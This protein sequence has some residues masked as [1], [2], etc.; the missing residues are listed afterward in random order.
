MS[1]GGKKLRYCIRANC[2]KPVKSPFKYC[3]ACREEIKGCLRAGLTGGEISRRLEIKLSTVDFY[4]LKLRHE[5][6]HTRLLEGHKY[7]DYKGK[8]EAMLAELT[9]K[10]GIKNWKGKKGQAVLAWINLQN[11]AEI[12]N[13]KPDH[14]EIYGL[15]YGN[16][17]GL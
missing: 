13:S 4:R 5:T 8:L 9:E 7:F 14:Y 3:E 10:T 2:K 6:L 17:E 12:V 16:R 15:R 11:E 1:R